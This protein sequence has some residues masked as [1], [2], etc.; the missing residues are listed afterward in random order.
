IYNRNWF[1]SYKVYNNFG[2][3]EVFEGEFTLVP[4]NPR[5]KYDTQVW[6]QFEGISSD[7]SKIDLSFYYKDPIFSQYSVR[8]SDTVQLKIKASLI[9][10]EEQPLPSS[11]VSA[12][13]TL[14]NV[15]EKFRGL[16][17]NDF[18]D[19]LLTLSDPH[20]VDHIDHDGKGESYVKSTLK[21]GSNVART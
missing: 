1:N 5:S 12:K 6:L 17:F 15:I 11:V 3:F 7:A 2:P 21:D 14:A 9:S 19:C 10:C 18:S 4:Q 13:D 20:F 8:A 16:H